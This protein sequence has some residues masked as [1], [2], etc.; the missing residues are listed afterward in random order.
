MI[1]LT[2]MT[3]GNSKER[4]LI[5]DGLKIEQ[6]YAGT[7]VSRALEFVV[8]TPA[9]IVDEAIDFGVRKITQ[10]FKKKK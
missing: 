2:Y 7:P 8:A 10:S 1:Q 4:R 9:R 3:K 5:G 6:I